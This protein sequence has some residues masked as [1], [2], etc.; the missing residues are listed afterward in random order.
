[1]PDIIDRLDGVV[2]NVEDKSYRVRIIRKDEPFFSLRSPRG[3]DVHAVAPKPMLDYRGKPYNGIG[4]E[5]YCHRPIRENWLCFPGEPI[6]CKK[7]LTPLRE[8]PGLSVPQ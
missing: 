2:L 4:D 1:M 7:C 5:T 6:T 8:N 3:S